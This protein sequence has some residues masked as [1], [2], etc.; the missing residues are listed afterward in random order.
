[1]APVVRP[2][3]MVSAPLAAVMNSRARVNTASGKPAP[4]NSSSAFR[5]CQPASTNF[6]YAALKPL[7]VVTTPFVELQA[8]DVAGAVERPEDLLHEP[9][10]LLEHRR[11]G[12]VVGVGVALGLGEILDLADVAEREQCVFDGGPVVRHGHYVTRG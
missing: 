2:G 3:H 1:M 7:G 12:V 9:T 10:L 5:P 8:F 4:P 6:A 11:N